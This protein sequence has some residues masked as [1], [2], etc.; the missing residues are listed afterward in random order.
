MTGQTARNRHAW[1]EPGAFEVA[2]GVHRIPLPLPRDDLRAVN[3]YAL[4]DAGDLVLIDSGWAH[5]KTQQQLESALRDIG[6][7]LSDV[8]RV[9]VTHHHY[10]H[11]TLAVRLRRAFGTEI[12]LGSAERP[13]L[14]AILARQEFQQVGQL[15]KWG[16]DELLLELANQFGSGD[17]L[18]AA[19][20]QSSYELP[21]RWITGRTE[22]DLAERALLAVPTPG[23]T[24]GHLVFADPA[25]RLLFSGDHVLPHIT[26]SIGLEP[27]RSDLPLGEFLE[28]LRLMQSYPDMRLLPAHG[29]VTASLHDR[30]AQLLDHHAQRLLEIKRAAEPGGTAYEVA[31]RLRWTRR[32]SPLSELELL[33]RFFAVAETAAHLDVLVRRGELETSTVDGVVRYTAVCSV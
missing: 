30:V 1:A 12:V 17:S 19:T 9:Y 5:E 24:R 23:H 22:I 6:H 27:A 29:P 7:R 2:P 3:A 31:Q 8:K 33:N 20:R 10:D 4:E 26:P 28:S 18:R 21:D 25:A 11:Y 16:A 32:R 14:E 13:S 15:Q